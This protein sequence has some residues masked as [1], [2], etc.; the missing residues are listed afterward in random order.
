MSLTPGA[1]GIAE[2]M[3]LYL[4]PT[5]AYSSAEALVIHGLLRIVTISSLLVLWP[6]VAMVLRPGEKLARDVTSEPSDLPTQ[7]Q[8]P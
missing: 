5:L 7:E 6:L 1:L 4:G 2:A 8:T 3:S